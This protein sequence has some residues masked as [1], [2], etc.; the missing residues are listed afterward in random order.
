MH[1]SQNLETAQI[2]I[3]RWMDEQTV[4]YLHIGNN[5]QQL[6]KE[7]ITDTHCMDESQKDY[8]EGRNL[9]KRIIYSYD[10]IYMTL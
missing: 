3:T 8:P 5:T 7:W 10:S 2:I 9:P 6:K 1:N 4:V